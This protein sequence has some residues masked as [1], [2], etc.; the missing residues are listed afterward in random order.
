MILKYD[1]L[2]Q[3]FFKFD[4]ETAHKIVENTLHYT[5]ALC[6]KI[7]DF[8]SKYF[9]FEDQALE[10]NIFSTTYKNP[11]GIG[12][13]F[14][15]NATMLSGLKSLGFGYLECGTFTPKPQDGNAKPRLF[16]LIDE[17]SIQNAMGFNNKGSEYIKNIVKNKYPFPIPLWANI[18]KNK[19]TPNENAICDYE[20]LVNDFN[21]ICDAFVVNISSPNTPNLRDLQEKD[22]IKELF[23][24]LKNITKKP[25]ILKISPDLE[26][27][28]AI[29]ICISAIENG[30]NGI[31]IANTSI[32]YSLSNSKNLKDFGGLSGQ[33]I[34][35]LSRNMFKLISNETYGKTVLI[36]CGGIDNA[37]EAYDRIKMGASLIQ[38]FTSFIY[39]GP[40]IC[41]DIN[42]GILKLLKQDGLSNIKDAI[43]IDIKR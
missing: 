18:G 38:I 29:E 15:K 30:A 5:D 40:K 23:L 33:N 22:F 27:K 16:R 19:L 39:K 6:P 11:V 14:D 34:K 13:G 37:Q 3:I 8:T 4:P 1:Y 10:Q 21:D 9:T 25:I 20:K 42:S 28:K 17:E 35:Q 32:N 12:G 31:I 7:F 36:A 43:G 2:K 41:Y 26:I 24:T